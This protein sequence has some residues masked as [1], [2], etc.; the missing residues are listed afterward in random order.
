M[1]GHISAS[2]GLKPRTA[3][4]NISE[5]STDGKEG[6]KVVALGPAKLHMQLTQAL[7]PSSHYL[8]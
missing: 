1:T 5:A 4:L 8:P 6:F 3:G 2:A 7:M